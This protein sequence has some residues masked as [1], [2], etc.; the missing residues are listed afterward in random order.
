MVGFVVDFA[1][2]IVRKKNYFSAILRGLF[3]CFLAE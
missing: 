3:C 1:K 2:K